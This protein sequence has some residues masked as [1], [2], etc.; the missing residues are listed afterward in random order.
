MTRRSS[1]QALAEVA[2]E[3][4]TDYD[5]TDLLRGLVIRCARLVGADAV[6][7]L[8]RS[9]GALELLSASS[10]R[11]RELELYQ[12]QRHEGP[13]VDAG[14]TGTMQHAVGPDAIIEA[15]PNVARGI[16]GA[17][18]GAVYAFPLRWHDGVVGCLN[19]FT[20]DPHPLSAEQRRT[21]QNLADLAT[22]AL[23]RLGA[24]ERGRVG[25][26]IL[27]ALEGRVVVEQAKGV[28]AERQKIPM[29]EAYDA[30]VARADAQGGALTEAAR[31]VVE[32]AARR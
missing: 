27:D 8:V 29:D 11:A 26:N 14:S 10:H 6:G 4:V 22:L 1:A 15:W 2:S 17:G 25:E 9:D 24:S 3:L 5:V 28:L 13:C 23:V 18:F 31:R 21:A 19:L 12:L 32:E 30:L 7:L 16:V 20:V